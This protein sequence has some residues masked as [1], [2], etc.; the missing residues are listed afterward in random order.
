MAEFTPLHQ[1]YESDNESRMKDEAGPSRPFK[2]T[3]RNAW[4]RRILIISVALNFIVSLAI[5]GLLVSW[6]QACFHD[7]SKTV[8]SYDPLVPPGVE[9]EVWMPVKY[10][11]EYYA[12]TVEEMDRVDSNWDALNPDVGVISMQQSDFDRGGLRPGGEDPTDPNKSYHVLQGYHSMH[13]LKVIRQTMV[14]LAKGEELA[15]PFGHSMHCLGGLL[16]DTLCFADH[17]MPLVIPGGDYTEYQYLR[18]CRDWRAMSQWAGARTSCMVTDRMGILDS[19][20]PNLENCTRA[21]GVILPVFTK[22]RDGK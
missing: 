20:H 12:E 13:C 17:S 11:W 4:E 21:D 2:K 18:K 10:G 15:I 5:V 19:D 16:R 8:D 14:Q 1:D 3:A 6:K 22:V 9:E 7:D